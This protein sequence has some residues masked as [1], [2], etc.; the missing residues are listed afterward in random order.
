MAV[1]PSCNSCLQKG[2]SREA[3]RLERVQ[4]PAF[5]GLEA[6][7]RGGLHEWEGWFRQA[8]PEAAELPGE[9][10]VRVADCA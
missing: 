5:A 7:V 1:L 8:A 10:Q 9:W 4:V 3:D 6:S 2:L